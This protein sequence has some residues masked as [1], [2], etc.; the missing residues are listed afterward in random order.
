M[1]NE[2]I[3]VEKDSHAAEKPVKIT[4]FEPII[5]DSR[6]AARVL[7]ENEILYEGDIELGKIGFCKIEAQQG[8]LTGS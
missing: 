7:E 2:D 6:N 5:T 8:C 4:A 3:F 1:L